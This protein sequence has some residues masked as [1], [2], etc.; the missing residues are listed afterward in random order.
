M[1]TI[2]SMMLDF[3]CIVLPRFLYVTSS[4]FNE[5]KTISDPDILDRIDRFGNE[6]ATLTKKL[7]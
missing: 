3:R 2:N 6:I 7:A 4:Q 1:P 5:D